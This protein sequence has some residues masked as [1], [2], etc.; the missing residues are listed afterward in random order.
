MVTSALLITGIAI[1]LQFLYAVL[2]RKMTD[3]DKMTRIM[4]ETKEWGK[5]YMD[6]VKKKEQERIDKLKK[7][8]QYVQFGFFM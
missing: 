1:A 5:Q 3:L 6:A 8:Q 7:K 2:R 4:K